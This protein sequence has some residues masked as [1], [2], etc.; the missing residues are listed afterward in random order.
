MHFRSV[1]YFGREGSKGEELQ[2]LGCRERALLPFR[3]E[4]G[5]ESAGQE[6]PGSL[7]ITLASSH[8][9]TTLPIGEPVCIPVSNTWGK[10]KANIVAHRDFFWGRGVLSHILFT[11]LA[12]SYG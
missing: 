6:C 1:R 2:G 11:F 12:K 10:N 9:N 3:G 4:V 8:H 7:M 5:E